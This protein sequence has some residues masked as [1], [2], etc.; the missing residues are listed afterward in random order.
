[1]LPSGPYFLGLPLF[2]LTSSPPLPPTTG[3]LPPPAPAPGCCRP[4]AP[5]SG[6][7]MAPGMSP[8]FM[9]DEAP[10]DAMVLTASGIP[11][12]TFAA[13]GG[14]AAPYAAC[15]IMTPPACVGE[16]TRGGA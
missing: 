3:P 12:I 9:G 7:Y 10:G 2:F 4:G 15:G 5:E 13:P 14:G 8:G 1:M 6:R 16:P 11:C